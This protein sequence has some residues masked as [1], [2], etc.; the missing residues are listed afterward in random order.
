MNQI[1]SS[2]FRKW[3][4]PLFL[5]AGIFPTIQAAFSCEKIDDRIQFKADCM[6]MDDSSADL[7]KSCSTMQDCMGNMDMTI[8]ETCCDKTHNTVANVRN[9]AHDTSLD[10][11]LLLDGPQPPPAILPSNFNIQTPGFTSFQRFTLVKQ[12]HFS[13]S[14]TYLKT[15][16]FRI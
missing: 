3:L 10:N 8:S 12:N 11:I 2:K 6:Q 1:R 7:S 9:I 13:A 5:I 4:V 14:D 15:Q 16:R